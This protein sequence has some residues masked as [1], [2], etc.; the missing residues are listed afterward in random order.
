MTGPDPERGSAEPLLP[1]LVWTMEGWGL[2][3]GGMLLPLMDRRRL[4]DGRRRRTT[5][6]AARTEDQGCRPA[7]TPRGS[8]PPC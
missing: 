1:L 5:R 7:G 8:A 3:S 2:E 4:L 6:A